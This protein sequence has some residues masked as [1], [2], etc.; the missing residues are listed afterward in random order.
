[1]ERSGA[2]ADMRMR[3]RAVSIDWHRLWQFESQRIKD[4]GHDLKRKRCPFEDDAHEERI[5]RRIRLQQM[6][7]NAALRQ[8]MQKEVSLRNTQGEAMQ[9][10]QDGKSPVVAI[11][12]TGSGKS[13]LFMLPAWAE[14]GGVTVVVVPLNGLRE[15]M[16]FRCEKFGIRCVV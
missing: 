13:V 14:A 2:N 5:E 7:A 1:M 16:V 8:I 15:D 3:F 11:M 6:N 9:A 10:I 12:P 4:S